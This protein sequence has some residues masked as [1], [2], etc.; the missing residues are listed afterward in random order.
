[1]SELFVPQ[2]DNAGPSNEGPAKEPPLLMD[3]ADAVALMRAQRAHYQSALYAIQ[4][5]VVPSRPGQHPFH[6]DGHAVSSEFFPMVDAPFKYGGPWARTDDKRRARVAVISSRL[7]DKLFGGGDSVGKTVNLGGEE[8]SIVGVL[9]SWN[10]QP[11]FYD[12]GFGQSYNE[13]GDGVFLPFNTA[14]AVGLTT[15]HGFYCHGS[16]PAKPGFA[17]LQRSSCSWVAFMVQ[18]DTPAQAAAYKSFLNGYAREQQQAG[19]YDWSPN[20]RLRDLTQWM[21]YLQVVPSNV[22]IS[23]YVALGM[24]LACL[25]NTAGLLLAK[26]MRRSGEIGVRRALGASRHEI[27]TQFMIEAGLVGVAGGLVG[28]I[29]T[30]LGVAAIG[31]VLPP[32]IASLAQVNVSL[33]VTTIATTIVATLVAGLYPTMRAASVQPAWQLKSN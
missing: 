17:A 24:L 19:R 1:S 3:Y 5:T 33:L 7:N 29:L 23:L 4:P 28:L 9:N 22:G 6:A 14:V 27:Y 2:I 11:R 31:W 21:D 12:L 13:Q 8:Y 26:F 15:A 10:P 16:A 32:G 30:M 25:V 20:N 18:L